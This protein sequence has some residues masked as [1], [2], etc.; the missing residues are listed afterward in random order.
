ME[1]G[2]NTVAPLGQSRCDAHLKV[3]EQEK[4]QR[5]WSEATPSGPA[6]YMRAELKR[7]GA[8][9]C[10]DCGGFKVAQDL[11]I[12]HVIELADGGRDEWG[13]VQVLCKPCHQRKTT[14]AARARRAT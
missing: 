3:K 7:A 14:K 6:A 2:C 9:T 10:A 1:A 12:D 4:N 5:R 13:N 8:W 11:E